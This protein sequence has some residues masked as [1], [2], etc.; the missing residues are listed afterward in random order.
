MTFKV[1]VVFSGG[2]D[3]TLSTFWA[4]AS[5]FNV[6][7]ITF[8]P[9]VKDS[10][11]LQHTNVEITELL[12]KCIGVKHSIHSVSGVKEK[13]V[14]EM[15][16]ILSHVVEEEHIDAIVSGAI[17]SEYQKQ[18]IDYIGHELDIPTFSPLW[19]KP[20]DVLIESLKYF[21]VIVTKVSAYGL[22]KEHL[23]KSFIDVVEHIRRDMINPIFE[24]GEGETLVLDAPFFKYKLVIDESDVKW[25]GTSGEF[26]I[27][28]A[29]IER[30]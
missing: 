29:H 27:K 5:G 3:S 8:L 23:G 18:R 21:D 14:D 19:H 1:I 13:E 15:L 17:E 11:M 20:Y 4:L 16:S 26:L 6:R 30:K 24:G 25:Y 9:T 10:Y 7:L 22:G 2:K 28:S 12:A